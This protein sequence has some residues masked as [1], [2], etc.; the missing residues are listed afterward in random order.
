MPLKWL[1]R[2]NVIS[3]VKL[4]STFPVFHPI[5]CEGCHRESF[6]G[7]R[8]KCQRCYNYHLCQ[9]CFWRGRI[10]GNHTNEHD[11]KEYSS[12]VSNEF[13]HYGQPVLHWVL[14]ILIN[15]GWFCLP[16]FHQTGLEI[17][18]NSVSFLKRC[19]YGTNWLFITFYGHF[20]LT[21][22]YSNEFHL[23]EI[24]ELWLIPYCK[25]A[26]P[27]DNVKYILN[28]SFIPTQNLYNFLSKAPN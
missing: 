12:W 10:S 9:D 28:T 22:I 1:S 13:F 14:A 6:M 5:Q 18:T 27:H 17:C 21:Q 16:P 11:V 4:Q 23:Q 25:S 2:T 15:V 24:K 8:Y 3:T 7:F 20:K 19:D 26:F